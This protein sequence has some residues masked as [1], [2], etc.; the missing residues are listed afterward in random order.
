[1]NLLEIPRAGSYECVC[2]HAD[3]S[4][5][6]IGFL[7]RFFSTSSV[8][9]PRGAFVLLKIHLIMLFTGPLPELVGF[10]R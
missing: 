10:K 6:W 4:V 3:E 8:K 5:C 9:N 7:F 2:V 1:M